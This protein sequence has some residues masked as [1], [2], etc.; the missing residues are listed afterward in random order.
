MVSRPVPANSVMAIPSGAGSVASGFYS[1]SGP[2]APFMAGIYNQPS[3]LQYE[4]FVDGWNAKNLI[5]MTYYAHKL[6]WHSYF[7]TVLTQ[8]S[9]WLGCGLTQT[10]CIGDSVVSVPSDTHPSR[11]L[12]LRNTP[13]VSGSVSILFR[14]DIADKV[15]VSIYDTA[16]RLVR[17]V[18]SGWLGAGEHEASWDGTDMRGQS[19]PHGVYFVQIRYQTSGF[20]GAKKLVILD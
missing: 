11:R 9:N 1:G 3:G 13:R 5:Q 19:E 18:V 10:N 14:L 16:G 2:K 20:R 17:R 8:V 15:D 7:G 12:E 6:S 4:S